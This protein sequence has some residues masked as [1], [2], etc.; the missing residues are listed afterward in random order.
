MPPIS[1]HQSN[2]TTKLLFVGDSGA[3]KTGALAS[4]AAAGYK[5]RIVD[6]DNGLDVLRSYATEPSSPYVRQCPTI[7]ENISFVTLTEKM[8]VL[9]GRAVPATATVWPRTLELLDHWR[10]KEPRA[11]GAAPQG[12]ATYSEDLGKVTSWGPETVLVLDTLTSISQ[13]AFNYHCSMN[14]RLGAGYGSNSSTNEW[15][16]DIG[17]A[18]T[19]I[20]NLLQL[21]A[22][23]SIQCNVI[24]NSHI[25]FVMD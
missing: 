2:N 14:A 22:D 1:A 23:T 11:P 25:T 15:R 24:L 8:R 7:A 5:L 3:G 4:L 10:V 6:T 21:L 18:Q 20:E 9:N 12:L 16:R 17:A 13:A 19:M